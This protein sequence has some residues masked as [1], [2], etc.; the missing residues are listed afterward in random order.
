[1]YLGRYVE[2]EDARN[3]YLTAKA[4]YHVIEDNWLGLEY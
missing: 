3:A 4:K 2:E 1:L